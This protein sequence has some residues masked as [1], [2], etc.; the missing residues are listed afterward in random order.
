MS[1]LVPIVVRLN[2]E[3][4]AR[5]DATA[6]GCELRRASLARLLV[7]QGIAALEREHSP[8]ASQASAEA[9]ER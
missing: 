1:K 2:P 8:P 6:R 4:L 3:T 9:G 5:L 7:L